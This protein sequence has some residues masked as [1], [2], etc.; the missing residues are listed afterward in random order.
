MARLSSR[1]VSSGFSPPAPEGRHGIGQ[2][3]EVGCR[4][5]TSAAIYHTHYCTV[6]RNRG[7]TLTTAVDEPQRYSACSFILNDPNL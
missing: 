5:Q 3:R 6:L 2:I 1:I 4:M 7:K